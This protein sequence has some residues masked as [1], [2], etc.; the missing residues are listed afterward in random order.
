M[1]N[2]SNYQKKIKKR[3]LSN[4]VKLYLLLN[5]L[6]KNKILI[7]FFH[8]RAALVEICFCSFTKCRL[9][10]VFPVLCLFTF[11]MFCIIEHQHMSTVD[12]VYILK[13]ISFIVCGRK[14][15]SSDGA[16]DMAVPL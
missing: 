1:Q 5:K 3:Y 11:K 15:A 14:Q 4:L 2:Y 7:M 6:L 12:I 8:H 10:H 13:H 9:K 16:G